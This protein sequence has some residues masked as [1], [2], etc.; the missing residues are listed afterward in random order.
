MF[1]ARPTSLAATGESIDGVGIGWFAGTGRV[2]PFDTLVR[3]I[4]RA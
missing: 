1:P 3:A 4:A 2:R